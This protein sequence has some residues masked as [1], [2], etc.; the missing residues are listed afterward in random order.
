[1]KLALEKAERALNS[2]SSLTGTYKFSSEATWKMAGMIVE[3]EDALRPFNKARDMKIKE[4]SGGSGRIDPEKNPDA[5]AA[6]SMF[7]SDLYES[8]PPIELTAELLERSALNMAENKI[9]PPTVAA[10]LPLLTSS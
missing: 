2:L 10:L 8:T 4:L 5:A 3:L 9:P 7:L 6:Y 1:M